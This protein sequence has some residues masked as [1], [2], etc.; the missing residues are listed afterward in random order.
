VF[1]AEN[2]EIGAAT[3]EAVRGSHQDFAGLVPAFFRLQARDG[4]EIH[5]MEHDAR[6]V[7]AA[8]PL[9]HRF[10]DHSIVME[11]RFPAHSAEQPD[12][13]HAFYYAVISVLDWSDQL[14]YAADPSRGQADEDFGGWDGRGGAAAVRHA[15]ALIWVCSTQ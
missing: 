12:R 3:L 2:Q 15:R 5:G 10:I 14:S 4:R 1:G 11:R 9:A 6:R 8:Q 7:Q 13:F